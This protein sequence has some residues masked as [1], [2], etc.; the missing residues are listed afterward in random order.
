MATSTGQFI[1]FTCP[2]CDA[3]QTQELMMCFGYVGYY[4]C[5]SC[6][7]QEFV[8]VEY[9]KNLR[10]GIDGNQKADTG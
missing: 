1:E 9:K 2:E 6:Q 4:E 8:L 10:R 3:E 5:W 7:Y